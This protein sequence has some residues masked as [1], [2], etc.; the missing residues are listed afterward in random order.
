MVAK[1]PVRV[2]FGVSFRA[3]S[4]LYKGLRVRVSGS[5]EI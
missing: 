3:V 2:P 5:E 4:R 1:A